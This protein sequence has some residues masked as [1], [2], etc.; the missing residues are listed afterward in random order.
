MTRKL[1]GIV[2]ML[3]GAA[4]SSFLLIAVLLFVLDDPHEG[5]IILQI[6]S[7]QIHLQ[8]FRY[9]GV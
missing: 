8:I 4:E 3:R 5:L 7:N 9:Q 1:Y 2:Q 6:Q